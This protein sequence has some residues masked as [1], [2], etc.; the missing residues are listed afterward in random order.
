M[1]Q[2]SSEPAS[3]LAPTHDACAGH[4]AADQTPQHSSCAACLACTALPN[5]VSL[6]AYTADTPRDTALG[7]AVSLGVSAVYAPAPLIAYAVKP[8]SEVTLDG[9]LR[10]PQR[11]SA[12]A[13]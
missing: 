10:P 1:M 4:E 2:V 13:Q 3:S 12:T 5:A 11:H 7:N 9:L 6:G 8:L